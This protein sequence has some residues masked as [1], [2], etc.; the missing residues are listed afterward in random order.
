MHAL[1][2]HRPPAVHQA[3]TLQDITLRSSNFICEHVRVI[4]GHTGRDC[5]RLQS[6][7]CTPVMPPPQPHSKKHTT[8]PAPLRTGVPAGSG[9]SYAPAAGKN[10]HERRTRKRAHPGM[11][12]VGGKD[13]RRRRQRGV[14]GRVAA[15]SPTPNQP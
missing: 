5:A 13:G 2:V 12:T 9:A 7:L 15:P 8:A 11:G 4:T 3:H 14:E 10:K 6:A 1:G